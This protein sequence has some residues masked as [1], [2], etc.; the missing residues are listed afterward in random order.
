MLLRSS[1]ETFPTPETTVS[2]MSDALPEQPFRFLDLP[3][4]L[5]F[6]VYE[7]LM[8]NKKNQ[9]KFTSP[10]GFEVDDVHLDG[11]YHPNLLRVSKLVHDEYWS[12]CLRE[13]VLWINYSCGEPS[14][15]G[16]EI[17]QV[18]TTSIGE[19]SDWT[20][21][22]IKVLVRITEVVFKF[23]AMFELPHMNPFFGISN[24]AEELLSLK[25]IDIWSEVDMSLIDYAR[26]QTGLNAWFKAFV[27]DFFDEELSLSTIMD[28]EYREFNIRSNCNLYTSLY[29]MNRRV[30]WPRGRHLTQGVAPLADLP[31]W[32]YSTFEVL[33]EWHMEEVAFMYHGRELKFLGVEHEFPIPER[34]FYE[35]T[36]S[37]DGY[38]FDAAGWSV[39]SPPPPLSGSW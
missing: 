27:E 18:E 20:D 11:M 26:D 6:M 32:G 16:E 2:D 17:D 24:C 28:E 21:L 38:E 34:S 8:D 4:E 30:Q 13:S 12:L 33:P 5:R 23:E 1:K 22:P 35:D 7:E 19:L 10:E 9:I 36:P 31:K 3:K 25:S 14:S 37:E 29:E 39:G 15:S